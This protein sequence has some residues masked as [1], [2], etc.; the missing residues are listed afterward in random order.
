MAMMASLNY[1]ADE[2]KLYKEAYGLNVDDKKAVKVM[3]KLCNHYDVPEPCVRFWGYNDSGSAG[4]RS[5]RL[6]H[7]PSI[8]LIMHEFAHYAK[9]AIVKVE[10]LTA[11]ENQGTTHHGTKFQACLNFVNIYAKSKGYWREMVTKSEVTVP[12]QKEEAEMTAEEVVAAGVH[13]IVSMVDEK[14]EEIRRVEQKIE[15]YKKRLAYFTKLYSTKLKKA[16][17]SLAAHKRVL[18][19]ALAGIEKKVEIGA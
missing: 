8:G 19:K 2:R 15:G 7:N 11:M 3:R 18:A 13:K 16:N 4:S 9:Y 6:S 5:I 17:R 14:K 1:Y 12:E 10:G